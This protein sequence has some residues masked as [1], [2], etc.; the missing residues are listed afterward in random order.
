[1]RKNVLLVFMACCALFVVSVASAKSLESI[2]WSEKDAPGKKIDVAG[3]QSPINIGLKSV[4][5]D[6]TNELDPVYVRLREGF[7]TATLTGKNIV[8][9]SEMPNDGRI[10]VDGKDYF[11]LGMIFRSPSEHKINGEAFPMEIQ[12]LAESRD[13]SVAALAL[14]LREGDP[15]PHLQRIWDTVASDPL[16]KKRIIGGYFSPQAMMPEHLD[17]V[18]YRGSWTSKAGLDS[19]SWIVLREFGTVSPEQV[20]WFADTIG[21]NARPVQPLKG[22]ILRDSRGF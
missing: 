18:R 3:E 7:Y 17:N 22:R 5:E 8:V 19:T 12:F 21:A 14:L 2:A 15:N 13:G 6:E 20:Q 4:V 11:P 9:E 1:M 10:V 16:P